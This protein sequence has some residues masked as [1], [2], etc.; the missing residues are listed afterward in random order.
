MNN[1]YKPSP[2]HVLQHNIEHV[3]ENTS[4]LFKTKA[5]KLIETK[6]LDPNISYLVADKSFTTP[7][8]EI[9]ADNS[10]T[11]HISESFLSYLWCITYSVLIYTDDLI[12]KSQGSESS[13]D[14]KSAHELFEYAYSLKSN[15]TDWDLSQINPQVVTSENEEYIVRA[16]ELFIYA[17]QFILLHEFSHIALGDLDKLA[18]ANN[19]LSKDER[20]E[21]EL[22]ADKFAIELMLPTN[23]NHNSIAQKYGITIA[24]V[25]TFLLKSNIQSGFHQDS[26]Q[27]IINALNNINADDQDTSWVIALVGL[28]LWKSIYTKQFTYAEADTLKK[29]YI[30]T[31]RMLPD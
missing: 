7:Y 31:S 10:K 17:I 12:I 3:F 29:A 26:D 30:E 21:F 11:I 24:L 25:S 19:P 20:K 1:T 13:L 27:R 6:D 8:A 16:N 22:N 2:I 9:N 23:N 4:S 18:E 28:E 14:I 15:Y 5:L